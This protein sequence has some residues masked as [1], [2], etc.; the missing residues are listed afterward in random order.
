MGKIPELLLD[1]IKSSDKILLF[2]H[3]RPDGD[4]LG[5]MFGL[6]IILHDMG[7]QVI[8]CLDEAVPHA[9]EFLPQGPTPVIGLESLKKV[10]INKNEY[11]GIALD[12]GD[13]RRLGEFAIVFQ[14]LNRTYAID[15]HKSHTAYGDGDWVV[16]QASSTGE[17]IFEL[18]KEI[19]A[20]I[21]SD[22]ALNLYVA[23]ATDTGGFRFECTGAKTHTVAGELIELGVRPEAVGVQLYDNWT[24]Q[25]I[26]LMELVLATLDVNYNGQI[27]T[28]YVDQCMLEK[29]R[30]TLDDTDGFVDYPRSISSVKV[31]AF[32]KDTGNGVISISVRAKGECDVAMVAEEFGGGGHRNAA[33]FRLPNIT[34]LEARSQ[35]VSALERALS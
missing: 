13:L 27:A 21:S 23:I 20:Y 30:T 18:A 1:Y 26:R 28:V 33:G 24:E 14:D 9:Y 19:D 8:C 17:L 2:T 12:A 29:T 4:A 10:I 32:I 34:V 6:A 11:L 3:V 5:S 16:P 22:A 25:R 15:H 7:K 35:V 31:A